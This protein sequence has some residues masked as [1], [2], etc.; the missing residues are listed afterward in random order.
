MY[1]H[2][3]L[4][5]KSQITFTLYFFPNIKDMHCYFC[6]KKEK[7]I[8]LVV[9]KNWGETTQRPSS[10]WLPYC[11]HSKPIF[12]VDGASSI[13]SVS[14]GILD[15]F[16]GFQYWLTDLT[17][18]TTFIYSFWEGKSAT[19]REKNMRNVIINTLNTV[20]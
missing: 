9:K 13:A 1:F 2:F 3:L 11:T 15:R 10:Y 19:L 18:H 12:F 17:I 20:Y 7:H 8:S 4:A 6:V 16:T 14:T 5:S